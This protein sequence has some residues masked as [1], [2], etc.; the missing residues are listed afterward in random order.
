MI[1]R[2]GK[3]L[4]KTDDQDNIIRELKN[5]RCSICC[6]IYKDN[7]IIM[8]CKKKNILK[9]N[10]HKECLDKH[11]YVNRKYDCSFCPYCLMVVKRF[12]KIVI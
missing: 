12:Y 3:Q 1:L 10:Y 9:H 8:C 11:K 7:D 2:N 4:T 5:S 6:E